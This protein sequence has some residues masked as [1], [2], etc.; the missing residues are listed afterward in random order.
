MGT[1]YYYTPLPIKQAGNNTAWMRIVRSSGAGSDL[2]PK[3]WRWVT[4]VVPSS[5]PGFRPGAWPW[6]VPPTMGP[7]Q[8]QTAQ[9]RSRTVSRRPLP[10]SNMF[11]GQ[12]DVYGP[13]KNPATHLLLPVQPHSGPIWVQK[14]A[15]SVKTPKIVVSR[16]GWPKSRFRWHFFPMQPPNHF[17]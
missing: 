9:K 4:P 11:C 2:G 7:N 3:P 16:A 6:L 12:L 15:H 13:P 10:G 17:W 14:H 8:G 1:K 5:N